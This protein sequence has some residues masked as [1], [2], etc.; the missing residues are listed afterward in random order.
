M[1]VCYPHTILY[2]ICKQTACPFPNHLMFK[3]EWFEY[4]TCMQFVNKLYTPFPF[5][6]LMEIG[7]FEHNVCMRFANK[8]FTP[9]PFICCLKLEDLKTIFVC[10]MKTKFEPFSHSFAVRKRTI[11]IQYLHAICKQSL[12]SFFYSIAVWILFV[13]RLVAYNIWME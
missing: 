7:R 4:N 6:L 10:N 2:A 5:H 9:F 13:I 1:V 8:V 12:C 3:I 11:W